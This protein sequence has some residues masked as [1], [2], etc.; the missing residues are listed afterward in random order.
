MLV[1]LGKVLIYIHLGLAGCSVSSV[2]VMEALLFVDEGSLGYALTESGNGEGAN[3]GVYQMGWWSGGSDSVEMVIG[4]IWSRDCAH[5]SVHRPIV[6][7]CHIYIYI[8]HHRPL[9]WCTPHDDV[10]AWRVVFI[11]SSFLP[12][13][14]MEC[15]GR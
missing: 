14:T 8:Y 9:I 7:S 12:S 1:S 13:D 4:C 2:D 10:G 11:T 6:N 3:G 15:E 5:R